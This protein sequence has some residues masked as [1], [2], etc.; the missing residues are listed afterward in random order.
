MARLTEAEYRQ[1]AA[2]TKPASKVSSPKRG[3][4]K[5]SIAADTWTRFGLPLPVT[6]V[7]VCK[8]RLWRVD[9]VW[10]TWNGLTCRTLAVE[11][12]GGTWSGGRHSRGAAQASDF[13]KGQRCA[14]NGWHRMEFTTRQVTSGYA[15]AV[16]RAWIEGDS[17]PK[18]PPDPEDRRR[19]RKAGALTCGQR[20]VP[21]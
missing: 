20:R 11:V 8:D 2:R 5:Q 3:T 17:A 15:A 18:L 14:L 6:E 9:F 10:R 16:V 1:M 13:V 4:A 21:R 19:G 12:H 7:R